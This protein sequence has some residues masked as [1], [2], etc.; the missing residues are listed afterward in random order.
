MGGNG[1]GLQGAPGPDDV[2]EDE[3]D[4]EGDDG[5]GAHGEETGTAVGEGEGALEVGVGR[6]VG[7]IVEACAEEEGEHGEQGAGACEPDAAPPWRAG[8]GQ[9]P[10]PSAPKGAWRCCSRAGSIPEEFCRA[11]TATEFLPDN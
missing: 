5:H 9:P 10:R 11:A 7:G 8:L 2:G 1:G 6:V 3:G 4:E